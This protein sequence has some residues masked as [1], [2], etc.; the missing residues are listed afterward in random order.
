MEWIVEAGAFWLGTLAWLAG[1]AVVFAILARLTPCNPG[2]YWWK[3]LR[4]VGTDFVYW[5]IVPLFLN[6]GRTLMLIA[7][8]ALLYG[9]R[10]PHFLPVRELPLWQQCLAILLIQDV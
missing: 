4:A 6:R 7:G 10:D 1:L 8:V 3:D 2:S 9:G 5:F